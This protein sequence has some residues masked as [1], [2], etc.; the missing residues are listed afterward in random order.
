MPWRRVADALGTGSIPSEMACFLGMVCPDGRPHTAGVGLAQYG[1][2]LYFTSGPG[3]RKARGLSANPACTLALRLDGDD[4]VFEGVAH[5]I[6]DSQTPSDV[7][8]AFRSGG[9]PAQADGDAITAV[10][11]AERRCAS[12]AP[13]SVHRAHGVRRWVAGAARRHP[14]ALLS[15]HATMPLWRGEGGPRHSSGPWTCFSGRA[16]A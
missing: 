16:F 4:V 3:T 2:D 14:V 7:A 13:V 1:G 9:W 11:R 10:Q 6:T 15:Q 5:R 12:A 8:A